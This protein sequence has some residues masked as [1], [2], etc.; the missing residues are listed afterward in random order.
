MI[1]LPVIKWLPEHG[2]YQGR[3]AAKGTDS[4]VIP[5]D[6]FAKPLFD[7][8]VKLEK[9]SVSDGFV[10]RSRGKAPKWGQIS[11]LSPIID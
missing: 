5:W 8:L 2:P 4:P 3:C 10:K 1:L 11:N 7:E 6:V 9:S